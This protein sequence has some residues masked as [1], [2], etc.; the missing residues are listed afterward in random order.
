MI[1]ETFRAMNTEIVLL[2]EGEE[3][4]ARKGFMEA[5]GFIEASE[6]RFT[7][8]SE[9]SE[10]SHFNRSAGKW[11]PVSR[12]FFE[13]MQAA[14][15]C[16]RR[17][18]GLFDPSILPQLRSAGYTR[19]M[20][21]IR[22]NGAAAELTQKIEGPRTSFEEIEMNAGMGS[23]RLPEGMQI[24]LGGIAKGWIAERAVDILQAHSKAC[25]VNAGGDMFLRGYPAGQDHWEVELEDP[26]DTIQDLAILHV[27]P[28]AI[29]TSSVA[30]RVWKQGGVS[31]HH[32]IDPRT[33]EPAE[34]RWLCV[35]VMAEHATEAET[36]AKA[37]LIAGAAE[38][39]QLGRENPELTALGVN[40]AGALI[41][42]S[43]RTETANVY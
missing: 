17:T 23:I 18:K 11:F 16:H 3:A 1:D 10:L 40:R 5:R 12:D 7:R 28:G 27:K 30:R 36:F 34:T 20:D 22:V 42:I 15:D 33:G 21:A 26:R 19:S 9:D 41:V 38:A 13:V 29:A 6:R 14:A 24:D 2:A 37:F 8:F 25:A 39:E 31:R 32:L 43:D 35:T 4:R